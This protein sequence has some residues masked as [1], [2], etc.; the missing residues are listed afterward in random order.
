MTKSVGDIILADDNFATIVVGVREG[1]RMQHSI[2]SVVSHLLCAN[3]AEA[4]AIMLALAFAVDDEGTPVY[5][6]APIAILWINVVS[7]S[8][9]ALALAQDS[10]PSDLMTRPPRMGS[11]LTKTLVFEVLLY[12]LIMGSMSLAIFSV[13]IWGE[14]DGVIGN[15]CNEKGG[16]E[17]EDCD[18]VGRARGAT[19]ILLNT[20]LLVHAFNC[21]HPTASTTLHAFKSPNLLLTFAVVVGIG[22]AVPLLYIPVISTDF[23]KHLGITWEWGLVV[24][25]VVVFVVVSEFYKFIRRVMERRAGRRRGVSEEED[26]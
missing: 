3:V 6:L 2:R 19:F 20:M 12:G 21:R 16:V 26:A 10:P 4:I 1:R 23:V 17:D 9:P 15:N 24:A 22:A 5:I 18:N 11:F 8:F 13:I 25:F 7:V 14:G